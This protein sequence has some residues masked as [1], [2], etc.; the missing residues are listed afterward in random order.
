MLAWNG[1]I[2]PDVWVRVLDTSCI[3]W[4]RL[5]PEGGAEG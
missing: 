2:I 3:E 1:E 5:G 4:V